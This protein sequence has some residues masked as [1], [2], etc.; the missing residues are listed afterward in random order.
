MDNELF[1]KLLK[2]VHP[3][4][5]AF[6]RKLAGG[7]D[8]GDD[9]YQ[10]GLLAALRKFRT[11][12]D[13]AAFRPWLFRILVNTFRNRY[14]MNWRRRRVDLTPDMLEGIGACD[15][16]SR[17]VAHQCLEQVLKVLSPA[18]RALV[19]LF[20]I[21]GWSVRDLA[22]MSGKPEGTV[23]I[24]LSRARRKMRVAIGRRLPKSKT[25]CMIKEQYALQRSETPD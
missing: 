21:Q 24:R 19:I 18:D 11:L 13:P 5:A 25:A 1:W 9:L 17:F 16:G 15:P 7:R 10:D 23:K 12:R 4:A 3:A 8:R 22:A 20:E 6:C 2:P 14:R